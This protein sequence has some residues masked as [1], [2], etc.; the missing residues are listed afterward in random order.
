[1]EPNI[2][3]DDIFNSHYKFYS[4][5]HSETIKQ[6]AGQMCQ[7]EADYQ[8]RVLYELIQNAVDR[9]E[10]RIKIVLE[11]K[12]L[13]VAN[14]GQW[15]TFRHN[16]DYQGG[17]VPRGDFQALCSISTSA[18]E[19]KNSIGN[20]GVGFKSTFSVSATGYVNVH[21]S[22]QIIGHNTL[23]PISFR[24]YNLFDNKEEVSRLLLAD[25]IK[26]FIARNI[27]ISQK[28]NSLWGVPGYYF[29]VQIPLSKE[30]KISDW[31]A[32][33]FVTVIEIPVENSK[34]IANLIKE[35][36]E[37]HFRF[38]ATKYRNRHLD[39]IF[40]QPGELPKN[41][42]TESGCRLFSAQVLPEV[43]DKAKVAGIKLS[44]S[45]VSV[46][47][48]SHEEIK[49]SPGRLYNYLATN[50]P[51]PFEGVD[52]N[53]DFY[54]TVD[55]K[56][57][58]MD[59]PVG[60][61]NR[62]LLKAC[63]QFYFLLLAPDI[64]FTNP[65]IEV[66]ESTGVL[67]GSAEFQWKWIRYNNGND[68]QSLEIL[69][70]ILHVANSD[71]S[72]TVDIMCKIAA[73]YFS[74]RQVDEEGARMFFD[75]VIQIAWSVI[76]YY[77]CSKDSS[78][79]FLKEV[80]RWLKINSVQVLPDADIKSEILYRRK[81]EK[82]DITL[83][84]VLGVNITSF[85]VGDDSI[86]KGLGISKFNEYSE[87]Y[88]YFKQCSNDGQINSEQ[89]SEGVQLDLFSA[90][91]A[92]IRNS[93]ERE[94]CSADRM[95]HFYTSQS[96]EN[97]RVVNQAAFA[98]STLFYKTVDGKYKPG[99]LLRCK[100]IDAE[101]LGR[102]SGSDDEK[103]MLLKMTGVSFQENFFYADRRIFDSLSE[104]LD[105]LPALID[106]KTDTDKLQGKDIL[107]NINVFRYKNGK[108]ID[109]H[110]SVIN[111]RYDF[112]KK[113]PEE[114][115]LT[116]ELDK[117]LVRQYA[118]F[119]DEYVNVLVKHM[120]ACLVDYASEIIQFYQRYAP[121]LFI[122]RK[123]YL[124]MKDRQLSWADRK[125]F[126]VVESK[127]MFELWTRNIPGKAV[128]CYTAA[129]GTMP[130]AIRPR[131]IKPTVSDC[132]FKVEGPDN[133]DLK[134]RLYQ[135]II[136]LIYLVSNHAQS[137]VNYLDD[138]CKLKE[139]RD[140]LHS[141]CIKTGSGLS[142][143]VIFDETELN[144]PVEYAINDSCLY[145]EAGCDK[146]VQA[147]AV[148]RYLFNNTSV[149]DSLELVLF[150][151]TEEELRR[152]IGGQNL[153][154]LHKLWQEDYETKWRAFE[155]ELERRF[156]CLNL[157]NDSKWFCFDAQHAK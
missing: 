97:Y 62:E 132:S 4:S 156:S 69:R 30:D 150:H 121:V 23:V 61:Y 42:S 114:S 34:E 79:K 111:P 126:F 31:F 78:Y 36:Q 144:N 104:G 46:Y 87:V 136:Y 82:G 10:H 113:V 89:I 26:E 120:N 100:D 56:S 128:L 83:P 19:M 153:K 15:F 108:W 124:I 93:K 12:R 25:D 103:E 145:L 8:G 85:E 20:K 68:N 84:D 118:D 130:Q 50:L 17:S 80:G 88:K 6:Q 123:H 115:K 5:L 99:Q 29:P 66:P 76:H 43:M 39:I 101:F 119:P 142:R 16:Y 37:S 131:L 141:L 13:L 154:M 75:V 133:E 49:S 64:T 81:D 22:G 134:K 54:T 24:L 109:L 14:D 96:R 157:K 106:V 70:E 72:Y 60:E 57:I 146:D 95:R 112:L 122:D 40:E 117:L 129:D 53:A 47:F 52:F 77:N 59:G 35:I 149:A 105:Y 125:D 7:V 137:E 135:K 3:V 2:L 94:R 38:I 11:G 48:R 1:M 51:S 98:L 91:C 139:L 28:E 67:A 147:R 127:S 65:C 86:N 74:V 110:P 9:A 18:K 41:M 152:S 27:D 44:T 63:Y 155:N 90:L 107:T 21:T 140:K 32:E 148:S 33:G 102:I 73:Q 92:L 143:K 116:K 58:N 55:R 151:K 45:A 138:N 71:N